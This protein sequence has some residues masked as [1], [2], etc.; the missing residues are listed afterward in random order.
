MI[1]TTIETRLAYEVFTPTHMRMHIAAMRSMWQYLASES[2]SITAQDGTALAVREFADP[3]GNRM[4][5]FD[6]EPGMVR[7]TYNVE[8]DHRTVERPAELLEHRISDLPDELLHWL[9]PTRFCEVDKL[10]NFA[11]GQFGHLPPGFG[12]VQAVVDWVRMNIAYLVGS[13]GGS[14][15]AADVL[16]Q[17]AGVCRDFAHLA[18]TLCRALNIPARLVVGYVIFDEPPQD[19]HAIFEVWLGRWI[20]FDPTGLA[21]TERFVRVGVGADAKDVAFATTFGQVALRGMEIDLFD[22]DDAT[23]YRR[24]ADNSTHVVPLPPLM[25]QPSGAPVIASQASAPTRVNNIRSP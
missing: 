11:L 13:S 19:F 20:P 7:L 21:P 5:R 12:R 9:A 3:N 16:Q 10:G 22:T 17:R 1:R 4:H 24:D 18:I 14:T 6:A 2:L 23:G 8:V 15:T 25:A